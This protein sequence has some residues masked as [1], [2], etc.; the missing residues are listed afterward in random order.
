KLHLASV[1]LQNTDCAS[2]APKAPEL[3]KD[4]NAAYGAARS[5]VLNKQ[6]EV[7]DSSTTYSTYLKRYN[8]N[9]KAA[10]DTCLDPT[11]ISVAKDMLAPDFS[12][13]QDFL[14][15]LKKLAVFS[16]TDVDE[17]AKPKLPPV[18]WAGTTWTSF[19]GRS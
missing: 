16:D 8:A 12:I 1:K 17:T 14:N 4:L 6:K 5:E 11:L 7:N 15:R 19:H 2:G 18:N 10:Q 9:F 13:Y 3:C